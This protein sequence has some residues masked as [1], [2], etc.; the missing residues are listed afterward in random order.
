MEKKK[1]QSWTSVDCLEIQ[2]L[3]Q[4]G[5]SDPSLKYH[6]SKPTPG[7]CQNTP[8]VKLIQFN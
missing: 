3:Y 5:G 6:K 2:N 7:G 8:S 1:K 4:D